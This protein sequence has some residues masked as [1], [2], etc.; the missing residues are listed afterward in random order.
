MSGTV[1]LLLLF[2]YPHNCVDFCFSYLP[3]VACRISLLHV[4]L[5]LSPFTPDLIHLE[6]H[7][8]TFSFQPNTVPP[9]CGR[10]GSQ[11]QPKT[12]GVFTYG[13]PKCYPLLF[14]LCLCVCCHALC[15]AKVNV[16]MSRRGFFSLCCIYQ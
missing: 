2:F 12:R 5:L 14:A 7:H 13:C 1:C 9:P 16:R 15:Y 6:P 10:V 8:D 4:E 11:Q 3:V